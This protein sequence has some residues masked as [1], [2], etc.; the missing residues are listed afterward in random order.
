MELNLTLV[1]AWVL[2]VL[3]L[4]LL[5]Q[6]KRILKM[7]DEIKKSNYFVYL[8]GFFALVIGLVVLAAQ[9]G[10]WL[11]TTW[12]DIVVSLVAWLSVLKGVVLLLI[13][14]VGLQF[15]EMKARK[16][17]IILGGFVFLIVGGLML[18]L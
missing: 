17:T 15:A 13:P 14:G 6:M 12:K 3:G 18:V 2:V 9:G 5:V 8:G 4:S 1:V 11:D 10:W 7:Y 16:A